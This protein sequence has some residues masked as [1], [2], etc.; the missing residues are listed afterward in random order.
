MKLFP[1]PKPAD[2]PLTMKARQARLMEMCGEIADM[3]EQVKGT[4]VEFALKDALYW[5]RI[6][7]KKLVVS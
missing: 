3:A 1:S 7:S 6:A 2:I 5:L 4:H